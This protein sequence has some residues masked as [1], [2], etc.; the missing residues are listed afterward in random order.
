MTS[1]I[2]RLSVFTLAFTLL[3]FGTGCEK[4]RDNRE[5]LTTIDNAAAESSYMDLFNTVIRIIDQYNADLTVKTGLVQDTCFNITISGGTFP[6]TVTIDYGTTGCVGLFGETRTGVVTIVFTGRT[7]DLS[8]T[9][10]VT[11]AD[12]ELNNFRIEGTTVISPQ[13]GDSYTMKVTAGTVSIT[14]DPISWSCN[15]TVGL[16][17]ENQVGSLFDNV[18]SIEGTAV[19]VNREGRTFD[20]TISKALFKEYICRWMRSGELKIEIED[21]KDREVVYG[22][23]DVCDAAADCCD[24]NVDVTIGSKRDLN[25]DLR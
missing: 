19:G 9:A 12:Y 1:N 2:V 10:T 5:A 7:D 15:W 8:T 13:G 11:T 4:F 23:E 16:A 25:V 17:Q 22:N 21:L 24:N 20:V 14:T 3:L 18:Y 6:K